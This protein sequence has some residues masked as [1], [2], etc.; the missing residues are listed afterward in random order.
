MN[1]KIVVD[2]CCDI[3]NEI[4]KN[5][6]VEITPLTIELE[7]TRYTDDGSFSVDDFVKKMND[8]TTVPKTACPAPAEYIDRFES[9]EENVFVITL[10]SKLSGSY[11]SAEIAKD[12]Y[13]SEN[14]NKKIHVFDSLSASAG[15]VLLTLKIDYLAKLGK[16]YSQIVE[17]I[18]N[19]IKE[20]K[21]MF[22]LNKL[23]N[24]VKTGRMSLV[25]AAIAN[26]LNIK[27]V[28]ASNGK[29]EIIMINKGRGINKALGKMIAAMGETKDNLEE[30]L[31]VIAHCN[32]LK[33][34]NA[35]KEKISNVYNF[36]D[37]FIVEMR[38]ISS[39]YAN[40]GGIVIAF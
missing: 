37:I 3:T 29:G 4:K 16:T 35:L 40:D 11:N 5:I 24:L 32:C 36:K 20:M 17:S 18:S 15:E 13:L 31:L 22:V 12:I 28:L 27:P 26:V 21:T 39:T 34:A 9:E 10:S 33:R 14:D 19:Y 6:N 23:D 25:K 1:F 30:K 7:G 2:S 38:G 8:S